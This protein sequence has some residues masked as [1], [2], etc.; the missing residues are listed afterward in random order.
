MKHNIIRRLLYSSLIIVLITSCK[1]S[2]T[3]VPGSMADDTSA[4]KYLESVVSNAPS[5]SSFASKMRMTVNLDGKEL[6]VSGNLK[7][8][9]NEAIQLSIAPILG[10]EV[11]RIEI[12]PENILILDRMN[13]RYIQAPV[14]LLQSLGNTDLDFYSLQSLFF[15]ELFLPGTFFVTSEDFSL[16]TVR[17]GL[18]DKT[19][20]HIKQPKSIDY[21]FV[22]LTATGQLTESN[23]TTPTN[24]RLNWKYT[25]F[26][27]L[28]GKEFPSRMD[29]VLAGG[30]NAAAIT[31]EL[32][33]MGYGNNESLQTEIPKKYRSMDIN[34][35]I[36]QLLNL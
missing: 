16:F 12:T 28:S 8:K 32:S 9:R 20:I 3:T 18:N 6:S 23:I 24:Y 15:N 4:L 13:K 36:K 1:S 7:I 22:T 30:K 2:K 14:S 10:I 25:D 21:S 19:L 5:L 26:T 33:K 11:A 31:L 35:L 34:E 17:K 27:T 29:I